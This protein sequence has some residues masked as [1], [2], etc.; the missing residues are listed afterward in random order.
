MADLKV[1]ELERVREEDEK[2]K[3]KL[4]LR[5]SLSQRKL[6]NKNIITIKGKTYKRRDILELKEYFDSVMDTNNGYEFSRMCKKLY[7]FMS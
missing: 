3:N 6:V 4:I 2:Q 1:N 7:I 5:N